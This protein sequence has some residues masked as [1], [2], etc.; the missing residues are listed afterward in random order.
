MKLHRLFWFATVFLAGILPLTALSQEPTVRNVTAEGVA[1]Y[2][3]S[4]KAR[5]RDT[6]L[7]D[8]LRKAVEQAV[9]ALVSSETMVANYQVL[10]DTIYSRSQGYIRSYEV[11]DEKAKEGLYYVT[12]RAEVATGSLKGD[13]ASLGLLMA[14]KSMP[15]V[16]TMVA[17]Q[18][19]GNTYYTYWWSM[20]SGKSERMSEQTD[21]SVTE[22]TLMQ[23]FGDRG[24]QVVDPAILSRTAKVKSAYGEVNLSH[25]EVQELGSLANAEIVIYGKALAKLAG[26]VMGSSMKS[27]QA[28]I[29][30]RAV[31][32]DSGQVIA[33][34][35]RHGAAVDP[36]DATA[37][38]KALTQTTEQM[39][40]DLIDQI[41]R[42]WGHDIAGKAM[43]HVTITNVTTYE[44]L[45]QLKTQIQSRVR[46]VSGIYQRSFQSGK[47]VLDV[48]LS[49]SAQDLADQISRMPFQGFRAGVVNVTQN[50]LD[51]RLMTGPSNEA[52]KG[53]N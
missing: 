14:R 47:A 23:V 48:E 7:N 2:D 30:L 53:E 9:G 45:V 22:N 28:D 46:G 19:I 1:G 27:A 16:M 40:D 24:F 43:V 26:T 3:A 12:V 5:A 6:A 41:M 8:A 44:N 36:N 38:T 42:R 29:S 37:G 15:R 4:D 33:S 13:L 11:T 50:T 20:F 25:K 17:E 34:A 49:G 31:R 21:L 35:T 51:V 52:L 18:N 10:S 32:T 39:A